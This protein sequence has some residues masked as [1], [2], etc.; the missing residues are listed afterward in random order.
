VL[1]GDRYTFHE[2]LPR[3]SVRD[4]QGF[5]IDEPIEAARQRLRTFPGRVGGILNFWDFPVS[6]ITSIVARDFGLPHASPEAVLRCEHK[7][8]SRL[9][10]RQVA[11]EVVPQFQAVD[12]FDRWAWRRMEIEPPFWVKPIK[13]FLAQLCFRIENKNDFERAMDI[14]RRRIVDFGTP[15]N[16]LMEY[17]GIPQDVSETDR[18]V[19]GNW[20]IAEAEIGGQQCTVEGYEYGGRVESHGIVD[21]F[22]YPKT[23]VFHRLQYPSMLPARIQRRMVETSGRIIEA[24]GLE[25]GAF[26]I[27]YYWDTLTDRI[28][29]LEINPRISQSHGPQFYLVDGAPN[30]L[31]ILSLA[32]GRKP[33]MPYRRGAYACAAK[34]MLRHF[35]D[36]IVRR[37]P[38]PEEARAIAERLDIAFIE[39]GPEPGRRLSDMPHQDSYSFCVA[40][41]FL[42]ASDPEQLLKKYERCVQ[43]L[44][45]ELVELETG[46]DNE[47]GPRAAA[48]RP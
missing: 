11:P 32:E 24:H 15:F 3:Q 33:E 2:L 12:P 22:V 18:H 48:Q 7:Y 29:L 5:R 21:S 45:F 17:V 30:H 25:G 20:M 46:D 44:P 28:W 4:A 14:G 6:L 1:S 31:V 19:D 37:V 23:S 26:N 47:G 39:P 10:Q 27:E 42:G 16:R 40:E 13:A 34:F 36:A 9:I 43:A 8:W 41:I 35:R 38:T